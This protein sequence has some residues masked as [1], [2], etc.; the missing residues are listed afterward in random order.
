MHT[1]LAASIAGSLAQAPA[2]DALARARAAYNGKKFDAAITAAREALKSPSTANAG[3]V[4][5]GR[6]LLERHRLTFQSTDLTEAREVFAEVR[7]PELSP[8]DRRDFVMGL[9]VALYLDGCTDG[10][11]G[12][13]AEFF[14]QAMQ[15]TPADDADA[16]EVAFEWWANALDRQALYSGEE[17]RAVIFRRILSRAEEERARRESSTAAPF[18]IAS[19][20]RGLGDFDRAWSAAMAGWVQARYQG[21]PGKALRNELDRF[22]TE[23]LLPERAK[24]LVPDSDPRPQLAALIKQWED[25]KARYK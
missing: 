12:A 20:A 8:R 16:R 15:R 19:A 5:L 24:A 4:V 7:P 3:A 22:V 9:G 14:E 1:I 21:A 2:P 10:C 18:W 17:E 6:A 11:L 13:A 25:V 23:V